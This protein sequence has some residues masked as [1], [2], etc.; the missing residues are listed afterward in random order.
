MERGSREREVWLLPLMNKRRMM[1]K[2]WKREQEGE[3]W[4]FWKVCEGWA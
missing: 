3:K 4:D 1:L 2:E